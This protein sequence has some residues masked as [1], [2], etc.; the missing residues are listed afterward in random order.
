MADTQS[1]TNQQPTNGSPQSDNQQQNAA[2]MAEVAD[3]KLSAE[4]RT[5][6]YSEDSV[7][8]V[9]GP[10]IGPEEK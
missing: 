5:V 6:K 2:Q 1:N 8:K 9:R 3:P 7:A 4:P 10:V